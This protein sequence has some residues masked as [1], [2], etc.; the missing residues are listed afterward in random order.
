MLLIHDKSY[1]FCFRHCYCKRMPK[2]WESL[3][4]IIQGLPLLNFCFL[5]CPLPLKAKDY[6]NAFPPTGRVAHTV[7]PKA[8]VHNTLC[9]SVC[10]RTVRLAPSDSLRGHFHDILLHSYPQRKGPEVLSKA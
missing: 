2:A 6:L 4:F 8:M 9:V 7:S 5:Q 10:C 3:H 1:F